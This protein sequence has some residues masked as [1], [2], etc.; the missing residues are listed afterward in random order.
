MTTIGVEYASCPVVII[1]Q[2]A[3]PWPFVSLMWL[4]SSGLQ[5]GFIDT[6]PIATSLNST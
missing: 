1:S 4:L 6:P 5:V 2:N 3:V